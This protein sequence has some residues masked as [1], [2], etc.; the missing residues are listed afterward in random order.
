MCLREE[1]KVYVKDETEEEEE[2]SAKESHLNL[3]IVIIY[4]HCDLK[5]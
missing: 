1:G 3:K 5:N 2:V 4:H